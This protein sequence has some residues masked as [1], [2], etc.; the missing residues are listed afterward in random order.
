MKCVKRMQK[1]HVMFCVWNCVFKFQ[2]ATKLSRCQIDLRMCQE[3]AWRNWQDWV[4]WSFIDFVQ[5]R[6]FLADT[7]TTFNSYFEIEYL[8][9]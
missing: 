7:D 6:I 9:L 4:K 1:K 2:H 5:G 8:L 3:V